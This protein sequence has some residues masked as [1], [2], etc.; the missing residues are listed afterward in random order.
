MLTERIVGLIEQG[1][2]ILD[3]AIC[4]FTEDA[5]LEM[6]NR[7]RQ[8]LIEKGMNEQ[9]D[10]VYMADI[11][12]IHSICKKIIADNFDSAGLPPKF[13]ILSS[14]AVFEE[15]A[16]NRALNNLFEDEEFSAFAMKFS[17]ND[18]GRI[19]ELLLKT[20]NFCCNIPDYQSFLQGQSDMYK[21][22]DYTFIESGYCRLKSYELE[23]MDKAYDGLADGI[24]MTEKE[25]GVVAA[26]KELLSSLAMDM[27]QG[28]IPK[29]KPKFV[30][31][32]PK[33]P[34]KEEIDVVRKKAKALVKEI[35]E[36]RAVLDCKEIMTEAA[37]DLDM[38][39]KGVQEF[40]SCYRDIK[41]SKGYLTFND[42]E[43]Y[44][45]KA[46]D[47][48]QVVKEYRDRYKYIFVDEY[49]DTSR[50]QQAIL[51]RLRGK[52]NMFMVGDIKQS[53]YGFR[54]ADPS[55][56][57]KV[58]KEYGDEG[59]N[60][61]VD[62]FRNYRSSRNI[63]NFVN[64]IF[65][66]LLNL[67]EKYYPKEAYLITDQNE[68]ETPV[69]LDLVAGEDKELCEA[70]R[71]VHRVEEC[72]AM[73]YSYKDIAV[74]FRSVKSGVAPVLYRLLKDRGIPVDMSAEGDE[75]YMETRIFVDLI[76]IIDNSD[77]DIPLISVMFSDLGGF[78]TSDLIE[79]KKGR[80]DSFY[81]CAKGYRG[82]KGLEQ[83][84][85]D[86]F[87]MLEDF[88]RDSRNMAVDELM[89]A[90]LMHTG[91][92]KQV[93]AGKDGR[94]KVSQLYHLLK[95][96][97]DFEAMGYYGISGFME[98]FSAL[99]EL[100]KAPDMEGFVQGSN[101]VSIM[102]MHKSKGLE[103]PVVIIGG[104]NKQMYHRIEDSYYVFN[105]D[106]GIG[107]SHIDTGRRAKIATP[108]MGLIK[109]QN[110][111]DTMEEQMRMLYVAMTRPRERLYMVSY[112]DDDKLEKLM[113]SRG[114]NRQE[115]LSSRATFLQAVISAAVAVRGRAT[116]RFNFNRVQV[117]VDDT[118]AEKKEIR[119]EYNEVVTSLLDKENDTSTVVVPKK[120]AV[121][122]LTKDEE[123]FI[124]YRARGR[125]KSNDGALAGTVTH[126][127][128]YHLEQDED[129][130]G[131]MWRMEQGEYFTKKELSLVD[132]D[133]IVG[134]MASDLYRRIC[135]GNRVYREKPFILELDESSEYTDE[136]VMVQGIIDCLFEEEDGFVLVDYK[137]DNVVK[138]AEILLK[139]KYAKQ[140][141]LYSFAIES[142]TGKRVK[143]RIIYH[144][145][146]GKEIRV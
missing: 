32:P 16:M 118:G 15:Q 39:L 59:E 70:T 102:T 62:L 146:T 18:D 130:D 67:N 45:Y 114:V 37:E 126:N 108:M 49:Q 9:A 145:K 129:F 23:D 34:N 134:F 53:I 101:A 91:Y 123:V 14:E 99:K 76:S 48:E 115:L 51:E 139:E 56:F 135:K 36:Y 120:A 26:D 110:A 88:D 66:S 98:Y 74:L 47:N 141:E 58:Y 143:E 28:K 79:I 60:I 138:N 30:T 136:A 122:G 4:T 43:Q 33:Q 87:G 10:M 7:I 75:L 8:R 57:H 1:E 11:A 127:L 31:M 5:T 6:K 24:A 54:N 93:E 97:K 19:K 73:G 81:A 13:S 12:T 77:N 50:L 21:K 69:E 116:S 103:F 78:T 20:Y 140:L 29:G 55:M 128:L 92:I 42:L 41:L 124:P 133:M 35:L 72:V 83:R 106:M 68:D 2:S 104:L 111:I 52:R 3:F 84:L 40:E 22:G 38:L 61:R 112:I 142:L 44:A 65:S 121:T 64:D 137:T 46:L 113:D 131:L 125:Q 27:E 80:R 132:K 17:P 107:L 90:V 119:P 144:L 71:I 96:A 94:A 82:D 105:K 117:V 100:K 85:A 63:L 25:F 86:F 95:C 109:E 89:S